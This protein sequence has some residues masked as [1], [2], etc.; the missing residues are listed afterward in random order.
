MTIQRQ[1]GNPMPAKRIVRR[2]VRTSHNA[3]SARSSRLA[4]RT[5]R[6]TSARAL[7]APIE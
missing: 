1:S 6:R 7:R 3:A 5:R 2:S 4:V